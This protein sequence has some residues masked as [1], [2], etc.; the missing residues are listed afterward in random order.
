MNNTAT[1]PFP[2]HLLSSVEELTVAWTTE[3]F[4]YTNVYPQGT[5]G[6]HMLFGVHT[7]V[8]CFPDLSK[9]IRQLACSAV[10]F[11]LGVNRAVSLEIWTWQQETPLLTKFCLRFV[12]SSASNPFT[13]SSKD[14]VLTSP[15]QTILSSLLDGLQS[16]PAPKSRV[17]FRPALRTI[18]F[19]P[20]K[21]TTATSTP[22][23]WW[24]E[25]LSPQ[26]GLN[27][28][29]TQPPQSQPRHIHTHQSVMFSQQLQIEMCIEITQGS[30]DTLASV[31]SE[32]QVVLGPPPPHQSPP[33]SPGSM[34]FLLP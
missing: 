12:N 29:Q 27:G 30:E 14:F 23:N 15:L 13:H 7:H 2:T 22:D 31:G 16:L 3:V 32:K 1:Q 18:N 28:T 19:S 20:S 21:T 9:Y 34:V 11:A 6:R 10:N 33:S 8:A 24:I 4:R 17:S 26:L 25:V 5:F